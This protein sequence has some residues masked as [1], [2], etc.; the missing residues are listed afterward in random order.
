MGLF[1]KFKESLLGVPESKIDPE[2][3][4]QLSLRGLNTSQIKGVDTELTKQLRMR[5]VSD[6]TI[7]S[8]LAP[9]KVTPTKVI[10]E[11]AQSFGLY[12]EGGLPTKE[13]LTPTAPS[14]LAEFLVSKIAR[15]KGGEPL[16]KIVNIPF[17]REIPK[18]TLDIG[19]ELAKSVYGTALSPFTGNDEV[20]VPFT[21]TKVPT[22]KGFY[23]K[24]KEQFGTLPAVLL[25]S[26]KVAGDLLVIAGAGSV[27]G[28]VP[29]KQAEVVK[30][31][32]PDLI[33]I[34]SGR[35][36]IP[37]KQ[38]AFNQLSR[39]GVD[40]IDLLKKTGEINVKTGQPKTLNEALAEWYIKN[41]G[42]VGLSTEEIIPTEK[43][44]I[45]PRIQSEPIKLNEVSAGLIKPKQQELPTFNKYKS[46]L[47]VLKSPEYQAKL[48]EARKGMNAKVTKT[49]NNLYHTTSADNLQSI[50][51]NGLTVGNKARFEGVSS[52]NKISFGANEKTASYY[53]KNGDVMIRTKTSYKPD[54]L[55]LDLLAGGEG[56]YTTSKNIPPEMLEVK[57]GSK[58]VSLKDYK[59]QSLPIK[60]ATK[61]PKQTS[62]S[63]KIDHLIQEAKNETTEQMASRMKQEGK[64]FEEFVNS[65]KTYYR[66]TEDGKTLGTGEKWAWTDKKTAEDW[67]KRNNT[68]VVEFTVPDEAIDPIDLS[69]IKS[70]AGTDRFKFDTSKA[71][72]KSQLID[73]WNKAQEKPIENKF[74]VKQTKIEELEKMSLEEE[75]KILKEMRDLGGE[76]D[77]GGQ[78]ELNY[79]RFI[80]IFEKIKSSPGYLLLRDKIDSGDV[81]T[82]KNI[83]KKYT[84][85]DPLKEDL[86]N[87]EKKSDSEVFEEFRERLLMENPEL[88]L[89]KKV[90]LEAG[91]TGKPP[92]KIERAV[93][94]RSINTLD[95][96]IKEMAEPYF[97]PPRNVN[98]RAFAL[99][100][101]KDTTVP[102]FNSI[103]T[104]W[105]SNGVE[106]I[107]EPYAGAFTLGAN[108]IKNAIS[109]G[110]KSYYSNIYDLEKN[111]VVKAIQD[112]KLEEVQALLKQSAKN[113]NG[114]ILE[115]SSKTNNG[116]YEIFTDFFK[117]NPDSYIGSNAWKNYI[118]KAKI[119][120]DVTVFKEDYNKFKTI[121]D[122]AVKDMLETKVNDLASAVDYSFIKKVEARGNELISRQIGFQSFEDRVFGKYGMTEG[123]NNI[124]E[125]FSLAKEHG[126]EIDIGN[127]N[128]NGWDFVNR[129]KV[130][131]PIKVGY[132]FDPPYVLS[133][134]TYK[135]DAG[136]KS[137]LGEHFSNPGNFVR[138][139]KIAFDTVKKGAKVVL[140]ND[141]DN[142]YI[143]SILKEVPNESF[144]VYRE[145]LTPTSLMSDR[146]TTPVI[147][148]FF[149]TSY[150]RKAKEIWSDMDFL[151][152][153]IKRGGYTEKTLRRLKEHGVTDEII[154]L[155]KIDDQYFKNLV[156]VKVEPNGEVSA[157]ISKQSL[158]YIQKTSKI[159]DLDKR[160][161][162]SFSFDYFKKG[163]GDFIQG[164]ETGARFF[165]RIGDGFKNLLF[166]PIIAGERLASIRAQAMKT[167]DLPTLFK[168][169]KKEAEELW[170]FTAHKQGKIQIGPD[171]NDL[172]PNTRK[173]YSEIRALV[174]K[175]Y[176]EV[177]QVAL[178]NG[179]EVGEV[180]NYSPLYTSQDYELL[181]VG[182]FEFTRR[183]PFFG[184]IKERVENVPVELY[185][186]DY[187]KVMESWVHGVSRFLDVGSRTVPIKYLLDSVEL[188]SIAGKDLHS[189]LVDWYQNIV[190]PQAPKGIMKGIRFIRGLNAMGVLTVKYS[191][192]A[193]QFLNLVDGWVLTG[194]SQM[195]KGAG[196]L[197]TKSPIA[198]YASLSGSV[199]QRALGYEVSDLRGNIVKWLR[200]PSEYTD[201]LTS[202]IIKISL[203]DQMMERLNKQGKRITP[204]EFKNIDRLSNDWIDAIMGSMSK[205]DQPA[206][207]RTELGKAVNM[208]YSQLNSKM[209]FYLRDVFVDEQMRGHV[210]SKTKILAKAFVAVIVGGFLE[211]LISKLYFDDDWKDI[212][213]ETLMNLV[214]NFPLIGSVIF[215]LESGQPYSPSPILSNIVKLISSISKGDTEDAI[216]SAAGFFGFA[217]QIEFLIRG[218]MVIKDG[219]VYDKKGKMLFPVDTLPEQIRTLLKGKWGSEAAGEYFDE[220]EPSTAISNG[221]FSMP[222]MQTTKFRGNLPKFK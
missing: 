47:E 23:N 134:A 75:T 169:S 50:I 38:A 150:N 104:N 41:K 211:Q 146:K 125:T 158:E 118:R 138:D 70:K 49:S 217:K 123:F 219:G 89:G 103:F 190:N 94:D 177:K 100:G 80:D 28:K 137:F 91:L 126:T 31:T 44:A 63:T 65:Q 215:A 147:T 201:K 168:L 98:A 27:A 179:R 135:G 213:K 221:K 99:L 83:A 205:A 39:E 180:A 54:D 37:A 136:T 16:E 2:L 13:E 106:T 64:S 48:K 59:K 207:F 199:Q 1:T 78:M 11:T 66:A 5:N 71:K 68:K 85:F 124:A 105:V 36:V 116:T 160:W 97:R 24:T 196:K 128:E 84:D 43:K 220:S 206:Y 191:V 182:G 20:G 197:I 101:N 119:G 145:G 95:T 144:Q 127:G 110:L 173:A 132:Y 194:S 178:K 6:Q 222:S 171:L 210:G 57:Q 87:D 204:K 3:E 131:D 162:K 115:I 209:Q 117:E 46:A 208:F 69:R 149:A 156:K 107:I 167:N 25:T 92:S 34:T 120:K 163:A 4:K 133:S 140:T 181:D 74:E 82:F 9:E 202:R 193:K 45:E 203:M 170:S 55:E 154:N 195:I 19:I 151:A 176:P 86:F 159:T 122:K 14:S 72:T 113:L 61:L 30:L 51:D 114:R 152:E 157:T 26:S 188:Q 52:P 40:F 60:K 187:R 10:K 164:Y 32:K 186:K 90:A 189:K 166:D 96:E 112:G 53:G 214:G 109:R 18:A 77:F 185:E 58:W 139:H 35:D 148:D 22:I 141:V 56:T 183:D 42:K 161:V 184:S 142:N 155:L 76:Q 218:G 143:K 172:T 121:F 81:V 62:S 153:A 79:N 8:F 21:D 175:L 102:L 12:P 130:T 111:I 67:A 200:K 7:S 165:L 73:I 33:D 192:I 174:N 29:I 212:A 17:V 108:S 15:V 129:I 88:L 93:I 216:W 198:K